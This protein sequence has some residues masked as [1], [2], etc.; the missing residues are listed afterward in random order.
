MF[1]DKI[2]NKPNVFFT[3]K[4]ILWFILLFI[5][6]VILLSLTIVFIL[7]IDINVLWN[8]IIIGL[9]KTSY[10]FIFLLL[11]LSFPFIRSITSICFFSLA[12]KNMGIKI[13]KRDWFSFTFMITL[14]V[15]ITPSSLGS[16]PY[17]IYWLNKRVR[18]VQKCSAITLASSFI[19][20]S[21]AMVVT[22]PSFIY[23]CVGFDLSTATQANQ[24]T[25]WFLIVGMTMDVVVL[26]SFFI[27][28]FTKKIHYFFSFLFHKFKKILKMEYK[29]KDEIRDEII[30]NAS[31]KKEVYKQLK[32]WSRFSLTFLNFV[33]YNIIYYVAMYLAIILI[34]PT[35]SSYFW[36]IFNFTNIGTT[37]N[38]FVPIPGSEGSLQIILKVLLTNTGINEKILD[39]TIFIWRFF[40]SQLPAIIGMLIVA[41]VTIKLGINYKYKK[42]N[43]NLP[44]KKGVLFI[45]NKSECETI[46]TRTFYLFNKLKDELIKNNINDFY[47]IDIQ[48]LKFN[49]HSLK[50]YKQFL[51][52][53]KREVH[54]INEKVQEKLKNHNYQYIFDFSSFG[55]NL[56]SR[57]K[58][59]F[60]IQ[61][62]DYSEINGT[63]YFTNKCEKRIAKN[64]KKIVFPQDPFYSIKNIFVTY[65]N[66][67][68]IGDNNTY[69]VG[70]NIS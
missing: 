11:L 47:F 40:T 60:W 61:N 55:N 31:F 22:W 38:N 49:S 34:D 20:Q 13:R 23:Y 4:K 5:F 21:S 24:I 19:G 46:G 52:N 30:V 58:N 44:E 32:S 36:E 59:Y 63:S 37:A 51:K 7:G 50:K 8:N 48:D 16:E 42:L 25:F 39:N 65:K 69:Y 9:T 54:N 43:N 18:N 41:I 10:Q 3:K 1:L 14:I 17:I 56:L 2:Q 35:T 53:S 68:L 28:V 67:L 62:I 57:N 45:I 12:L 27:L 66:N 15:S 29:S 26:V 70:N 33:F 6:T 64:M